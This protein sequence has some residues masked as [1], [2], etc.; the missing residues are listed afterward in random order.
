MN[1]KVRK[2]LF[3][4][5]ILNQINVFIFFSQIIVLSVISCVSAGDLNTELLPPAHVANVFHESGITFVSPSTRQL[6]PS[7]TL[8]APPLP[9]THAFGF[10]SHNSNHPQELVRTHSFQ[11]V[12]HVHVSAVQSSDHTRSNDHSPVQIH[13][14]VNDEYST[15][16]IHVNVQTVPRDLVHA[17]YTEKEN[18]AVFEV[19]SDTQHFEYKL[20]LP[21]TVTIAHDSSQHEKHH[22]DHHQ[23]EHT[24]HNEFTPRISNAEHSTYGIP[25]DEEINSLP[26]FQNDKFLSPIV[27]HTNTPTSAKITHN[28]VHGHPQL[29]NVI[30]SSIHS[31]NIPITQTR[32]NIIDDKNQYTNHFSLS[33]GTKVSEQGRLINTDYGREG[34]IAKMGEYKYVSP[35]G[36]DIH[37]RWIADD[38]GYRIV[39]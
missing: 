25:S 34:V 14:R 39:M 21:R 29:N 17:Q 4:I 13:G 9:L 18:H 36:K 32:E 27:R 10:V 38:K 2:L 5:L 12:S 1:I 35:E 22:L 24:T 11:P 7:T 19:H 6:E 30:S 26:V 31:H 8:L 3:A 37:V 16:D 28:N 20:P 15:N 33:D 23:H